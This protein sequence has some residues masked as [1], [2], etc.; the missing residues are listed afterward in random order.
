MYAV[1]R[2]RGRV[3]KN[4][5]AKDTMKMLGLNILYSWRIVPEEKLGMIKKAQDFVTWGEIN[6]NIANQ[7]NGKKLCPPLKG[8]RAIKIHYPKGD[9]GYRGDKINELLQRMIR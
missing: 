6:D 1:I 3:E 4:K 9:L 5:A 7:L 2:I 8:F